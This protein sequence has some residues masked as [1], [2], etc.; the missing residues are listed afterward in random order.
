VWLD[1]SHSI[2]K[3]LLEMKILKIIIIISKVATIFF[4]QCDSFSPPLSYGTD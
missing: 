3:I 2:V 4:Q 1:P